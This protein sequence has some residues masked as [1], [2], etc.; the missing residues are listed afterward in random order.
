MAKFGF[1]LPFFGPNLPVC[2]TN[3]YQNVDL[4]FC[5]KNLPVILSDTKNRPFFIGGSFQRLLIYTGSLESGVQ[6]D[7]RDLFAQYDLASFVFYKIVMIKLRFAF[8]LNLFEL[9]HRQTTPK[10]LNQTGNKEETTGVNGESTRLHIATRKKCRKLK[11][12]PSAKRTQDVCENSKIQQ[13]IKLNEK[14]LN[15]KSQ[16][17]TACL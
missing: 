3:K 4:S 13:N 7:P 2:Y 14:S 6:S 17:H 15:L 5:V 12:N 16:K 11:N 10:T 8:I 1:S 9:E